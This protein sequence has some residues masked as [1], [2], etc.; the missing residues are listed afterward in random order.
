MSEWIDVCS[1]VLNAGKCL[2]I[3]CEPEEVQF[4]LSKLKHEG[5]LL[6]I[7]CRTEKEAHSVLKVV[8]RYSK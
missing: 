7:R 8:E 6:S 2:Q 5:L 3:S 1:K 4:L